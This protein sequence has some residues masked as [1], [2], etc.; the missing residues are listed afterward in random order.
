MDVLIYSATGN[1]YHIYEGYCKDRFHLRCIDGHKTSC[2][3]CVGYCRYAGHE[4]FLTR[5]LRKEHNCLGKQCDYY[6]SKPKKESNQTIIITNQF[7]RYA[8]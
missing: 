6:L 3:N 2:G 4:G 5:E 7:R 8:K 1:E